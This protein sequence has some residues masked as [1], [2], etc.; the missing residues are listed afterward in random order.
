M[1]DQSK[2]E[3]IKA[4]QDSQNIQKKIT[5]QWQT[6]ATSLGKEAYDDLMNYIDN[7]REMF[8]KYAE[9]QAIPHPTKFGDVLPLSSDNIAGL[10]Q[11]S[12]GL[13]IIKTYITQRVD[14]K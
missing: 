9:N 5:E 11:T 12:R 7:Q 4:N 6:F 14:A 10:L 1:I 3:A 8:R 2:N 13:N